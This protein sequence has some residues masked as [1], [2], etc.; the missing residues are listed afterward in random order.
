M[1]FI[2]TILVLSMLVLAG[3]V[4]APVEEPTLVE[5]LEQ[6]E[7]ELES[8]DLVET[9]EEEP[10]MRTIAIDENQ[11]LDLGVDIVDPDNDVVDYTFSAPLNDD[12]KWDTN[13][14]DAGEYVV[15]ITATDGVHTAIEDVNLVVNRVNVAPELSGVENINAQEGDLIEFIPEVMDPNGDS[16]ELTVSAPLDMGTFQTDH[17]SAGV[18]E[19]VVTATDGEL[20]TTETV[21]LTIEDVNVLPVIENVYDMTIMEGE[22]VMIEPVVSDLDGDELV[23]RISEPIGDSGVWETA[24]TDNGVYEITVSVDDGKDIVEKMVTITVE[25]V[26]MAPQIVDIYLQ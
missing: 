15:T 12:G 6:I 17:T 5:E 11:E 10:M 8:N 1:R 18:Y 23:V 21:S 4:N 22:T 19:I 14:G 24:Y 9:P 13:Y 20:T 7:Q 3:C 16:I 25:D 2:Y 26:N